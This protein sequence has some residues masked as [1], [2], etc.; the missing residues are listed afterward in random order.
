MKAL[1]RT[2]YYLTLL[3]LF[4]LAAGLSALAYQFPL[5]QDITQNASN[6]LESASIQALQQMPA[7]VR[8]TV[9]I[10]HQH[11]EYGD[12]RPVIREFIGLYQRHKPDLTLDFVDPKQRPE[13]LRQQNVQFNGEIIIEYEQKKEKLTELNEAAFTNALMRLQRKQQQT[14]FYIDGHGERQ[15]DGIANHDMGSLFGKALTR[16]GYQIDALNLAIAPAVP[17]NAALLV[18]TQPQAPLLPGEIEKLKQYIDRGKPLLWLVD[19][20]P[21]HGLEAIAEQLELTL[22]EGIIIDPGARQMNVPVTWTLGTL[23]SPTH[24]ITRDF[25]LITAYP[26]A[27]P[28]FRPEQSDWRI[29]PLVETTEESWLSH[30]VSQLSDTVPDFDIMHDTPG[31]FNLAISMQRQLEDSTQRII[32]VGNG[33]FLSNSFAGNAANIDFGINL[34]NWLTHED[35]LISIQPRDIQ[36]RQLILSE[37][38]LATIGS[39]LLLAA[40][41][42]LTFIGSLIWWRRRAGHHPH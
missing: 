12:V 41:A 15:L 33:A 5:H 3:T 30:R 40:P 39:L 28:I 35:Q 24:A 2:R 29:H 36:D 42:L 20:G 10:G 6:T 26:G 18:I 34:I 9:F 37:N 22:P 38:E 13:T 8:V 1:S 32:V 25:N 19:P 7:P 23:Y 14:V 4:I 27:R 17:D 21:L 11:A 31:P 16:Q